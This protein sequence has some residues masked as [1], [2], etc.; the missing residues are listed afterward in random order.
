MASLLPGPHP[1]PLCGC[2]RPA[3][4]PEGGGQG[5]PP[6][7][8]PGQPRGPART[9]LSCNANYL[10]VLAAPPVP[11]LKTA[12][13]RPLGWGHPRTG[14]LANT[15]LEGSQDQLP[16][17]HP[18]LFPRDSNFW[19]GMSGSSDLF[20]SLARMVSS[21]R[22]LEFSKSALWIK[23]VVGI[24]VSGSP[25]AQSPGSGREV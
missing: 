12:S 11:G 19:G 20:L 1:P 14:G 15:C 22:C 23:S 24:R 4:S 13:R 5:P 25:W 8:H 2:G 16:R 18:P 10:V 7:P 21:F 9:A 17:G 6:V 3:G